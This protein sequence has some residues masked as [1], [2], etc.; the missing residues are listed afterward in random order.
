MKPLRLLF[1]L[2][3]LCTACDVLL[4]PTPRS[5]E[6]LA[7][8][9]ESLTATQQASHIQGDTEFARSFGAAD[10]LGPIFNAPSCESCHIGD[11]K[12]HAL[13][14]LIRFGRMNGAE[15]DPMTAHGGPQL[16]NRSLSGYTPEVLPSG[17]TGVTRLLPPAVTGLGYLAAVDDATL[18]ALADPDDRNSDGISGV[19]NYVPAHEYFEPLAMHKS[20]NGTYIGRFGRKA[21]AID[22][23]QQTASAYRNDMGI[24]SDFIMQELFNVQ[25]GAFTGDNIPDPEVSASVVRNVVFY[26]RTLKAPPRRNA[27]AADVKA[28][29]QIFSRIGCA[30]C[31]TP[32]LKTGASDIAALNAVEF[33]PYTDLLLHDMG[34]ELDD[35]YTEGS[36]KTSEW[37]TTPLWGVGLSASTQ[38]GKATY[39]H[40]GRATTLPDAIKAHGGE[41][42]ASRTRFNALSESE[43]R[44]LITFLESL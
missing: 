14:T 6:L 8:P 5:E 23:L 22:L 7:E 2:C 33:H 21:A 38:G 24:T 43:K 9:L 17:A 32:T 29:E 28:G 27:D 37:R 3:A 20:L 4:P 19:P 30:G 13:T 12:G 44:Q 40:D 15:F 11:G 18:L 36:A 16:Q 25:T 39:L 35:K 1:I 42:A 26:L 10:G 31:H 34:A 41:A